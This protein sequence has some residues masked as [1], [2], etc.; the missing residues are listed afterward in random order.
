V[1]TTVNNAGSAVTVGP[2]RTASGRTFHVVSACMDTSRNWYA[3]AEAAE[4][5]APDNG[6]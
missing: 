6:G 5:T 4:V 3:E 2:L 1:R